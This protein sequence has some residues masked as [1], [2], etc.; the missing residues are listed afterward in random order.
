MKSAVKMSKRKR[1]KGLSIEA[2]RKKNNYVIHIIIVLVIIILV[3][4]VYSNIISPQSKSPLNDSQIKSEIANNG[5]ES[6]IKT[7]PDGT[8][9]LVNPNL[10]SGGG[11]P[12]GGIGIDKGIP[13]L[14]K[15]NIKFVSVEE[16]DRWIEDNELVLVLRYKNKIRVYPHQIMVWHEIVNDVVADDPILITYCPLCGSGIAYERT[17]EV[18]GE[19]IETRFGTSG[20]L[21]NSNL[22][23][24]DEK[25]DTYWQQIGGLAIIGQLTGQELIPIDLDTVAWKDWKIAN[26]DSQVLSQGTGMKRDYGRDPYRNY[27]EDSFLLFPVD[28]RDDRVHPKTVIFGIEINGEYSAYREEDIKPQTPVQDTVGG[29]EIEITKN[30]GGDVGIVRLDTN[31]RVPKERDFWFAWYSFHPNTKLYGVE[32]NN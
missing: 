13:A 3:L 32:P 19:R 22:I 31:E 28:N 25:T 11:P 5:I 7:T 17:I 29:V 2:N 4:F 18:E 30:I 9:Y 10:I 12:K 20:K 6:E 24:Y 14:A 16:A 26:P 21:Y 23:M 1:H 15:E 27:Y 8:K